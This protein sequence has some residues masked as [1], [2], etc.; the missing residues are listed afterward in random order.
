MFVSGFIV[1]FWEALIMWLIWSHIIVSKFNAPELN[2]W[3]CFFILYMIATF[4][5]SSYTL[6]LQKVLDRLDKIIKK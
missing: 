5:P 2:Y 4:F 6:M 1:S 3:E